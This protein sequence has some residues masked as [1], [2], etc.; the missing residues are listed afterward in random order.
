LSDAFFVWSRWAS[1]AMGVEE[2]LWSPNLGAT[3]QSGK[4]V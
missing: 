3:A 2:V 4:P 1:L